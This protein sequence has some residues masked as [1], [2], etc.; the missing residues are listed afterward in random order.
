MKSYGSSVRTAKWPIAFA[1]AATAALG[2]SACTSGSSGPSAMSAKQQVRQQNRES[3]VKASVFAT[4][5]ITDGF[6]VTVESAIFPKNAV[7]GTQTHE[8]VVTLAPLVNGKPGDI[9][10]LT[11]VRQ[12]TSKNVRV[13]VQVQL[14]TGTY[15]VSLYAGGEAPSS[16][17]QALAGTDVTVTVS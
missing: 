12:G 14:R 7:T 13:P 6:S 17:Q 8:G 10:G 3:A 2:L 11:H 16:A 1:V 15:R 9:A 5:Q 4:D